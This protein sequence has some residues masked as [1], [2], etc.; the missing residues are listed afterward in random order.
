MKVCVN[1]SYSEELNFKYGVPQGSC[2]G[3]NNFVAYC[4]PI[5]EIINKPIQINGYSDNHS[6]HC[7]FN[8]N[9]SHEEIDTVV[10]LQLSVK[11]IANWMTSIRLK[12]NFDK[13]EL[14][15]FRSRQQLF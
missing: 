4:S 10:D 3:V 11:N 6:L 14:I 9:S 7:K 5:E 1:N 15:V 8:P 12:L 2:S 13:T